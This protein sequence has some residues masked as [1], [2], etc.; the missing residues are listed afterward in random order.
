MTGLKKLREV[1]LYKNELYLDIPPSIGNMEDL[2]DLRLHENEMTGAIPDSLYAVRK[3]KKL[4]L[5]DTV[6]CDED[7]CSTESEFGFTGTIGTEIGNLKK[8]QML[9]LNNNPLGG[10]IPTEIGLCENLGESFVDPA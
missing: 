3:L 6:H 4:W 7:G 8:L 10:T 5:Q 1:Y 9:M 2:E